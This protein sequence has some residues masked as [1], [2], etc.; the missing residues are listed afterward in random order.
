MAAGSL[1]AAPAAGGAADV[2]SGTGAD[3]PF[4][5]LMLAAMARALAK[6]AARSAI[7]K[8]A[9][10]G[11][12]KAPAAVLVG[13]WSRGRHA[14]G[15]TRSKESVQVTWHPTR[16]VADARGALGGREGPCTRFDSPTVQHCIDLLPTKA[17]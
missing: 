8:S 10:I 6:A 11:G 16:L 13:R 9:E 7:T 17:A 1:P 5:A 3:A 2:A 15:S 14:Q 12:L 4:P